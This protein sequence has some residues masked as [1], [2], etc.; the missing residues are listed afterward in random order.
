MRNVQVAFK[1][2]KQKDLNMFATLV[3]FMS[4]VYHVDMIRYHVHGY[5]EKF[6]S[7][8]STG[9]QILRPFIH[10]IIDDFFFWPCKTNLNN[11]REPPERMVNT[12]I[13]LVW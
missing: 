10:R 3:A 8:F 2:V 11:L 5:K 4:S 6:P 12:Q 7:N 1:S 13:N 9:I